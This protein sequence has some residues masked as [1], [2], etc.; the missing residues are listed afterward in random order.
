MYELGIIR[1]ANS[2]C[3]HFLPLGIKSLS[4]LIKIVENEM[5][6]I[7]GQKVLFPS[8]IN[9]RLWRQSGTVISI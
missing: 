7:G 8:L 4:K 2:G 3:F 6:K 5:F 1:Q 9:S